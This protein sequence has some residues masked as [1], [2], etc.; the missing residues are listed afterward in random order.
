MLPPQLTLLLTTSPGPG[1][2]STR[3]VEETVASLAL[4]GTAGCRLLVVADGAVPAP[5]AAFKRGRVDPPAAAA[6]AQYL[7]R[8]AFLATHPPS[9][10]HGAELLCL[11]ERHG[12]AH[13]LR[14]AL[15]RVA[16]PAV[17]V[18][19]HDRPFAETVRLEP[20]LELLLRCDGVNYVGFPTAFTAR[21]RPPPG[22]PPGPAPLVP[23]PAFIDSTFLAST[24]WLRG[25][26][27]GRARYCPL[28]RGCFLEDVLGQHQLACLRAEGP[29]SH[30]RFGT[31]LLPSATPLV[32][33]LDGRDSRSGS[34]GWAK[35]RHA[36]AHTG[37]EAWSG[38]PLPPSPPLTGGFHD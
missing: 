12:C 9:V 37:E 34:V 35:W 2:P 11:A 3:L 18:L 23:L 22:L 31:F 27:F 5:Q 4:A 25:C 28:P 21:R 30:A 16:T 20:L 36:E 1:H 19:Q 38:L 32:T 8:L 14:R 29:L 6:Y 10:L 26:V 13:A 7:R 33:H 17:L 15:H 24:A